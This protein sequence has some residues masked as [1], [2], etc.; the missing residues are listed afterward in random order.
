MCTLKMAAMSLGLVGKSRVA[1]RQRRFSGHVLKE[2]T[3]CRPGTGEPRHRG[4][5][6]KG[7]EMTEPLC[8][9]RPPAGN[10]AHAG[11]TRGTSR[12]AGSGGASAGQET[13]NLTG[14]SLFFNNF[15]EV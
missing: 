14:F 15:L 1:S 5:T 9:D 6:C 11:H 4:I 13:G 12:D 8:K 7:T 2:E 3:K 10:G